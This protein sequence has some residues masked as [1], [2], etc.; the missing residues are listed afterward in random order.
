MINRN[1][2]KLTACA[3]GCAA[4]VAILA[5]YWGAPDAQACQVVNQ[6]NRSLGKAVTHCGAS[7]GWVTAAAVSAVVCVVLTALAWLTG[8]PRGAR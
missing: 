6:V 8:P 7:P 5:A 4:V 3:A 2:L 1:R